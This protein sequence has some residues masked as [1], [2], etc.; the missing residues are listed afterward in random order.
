M[1]DLIA[2]T[3]LAIWIGF[4]LWLWAAELSIESRFIRSLLLGVLGYGGFFGYLAY[5]ERDRST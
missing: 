5:R 3:V 2:L 4:N 1:K